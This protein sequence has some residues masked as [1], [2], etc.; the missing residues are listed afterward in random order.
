MDVVARDGLAATTTASIAAQAGVAEGTLYR[1]FKAKDDLLIAAYRQL[2]AAILADATD[3]F[4]D[5]ASP[6]ARLRRLWLRMVAAYRADTA[7]FTF[8]QRFA[9]SALSAKEGGAA[10]EALLQAIEQ[11]LRDGVASGAFKDLPADLMTALF[12]APV[13]AFVKAELR[14][15]RWSDAEL[16]AAADAVVQGWR[17]S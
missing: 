17:A 15:R 1:H 2:K 5:A 6:D 16:E 3:G 9:E 12:T 13:A 10:H 7:A 11:L 8:G 14:G 4:D